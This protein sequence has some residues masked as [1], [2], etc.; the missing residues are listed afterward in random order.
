MKSDTIFR[1]KNLLKDFKNGKKIYYSGDIHIK[2]NTYTLIKGANGV[3]KTTFLNFL[4]T[5]D[6]PAFFD[7]GT[8]F[9]TP[10]ASSKVYDYSQLYHWKNRF[11]SGFYDNT[12]ALRRKYFSFLPQTGNLIDV[13]SI[14]DNLS[15][16]PEYHTHLNGSEKNAYITQHLNMIFA[17]N[18]RSFNINLSPSCLSGGLRQRLALERALIG[19][20][21]V[22]FA[23][24]PTN[25]MDLDFHNSTLNALGNYVAYKNGTVIMITHEYERA[26][27]YLNKQ[28]ESI[29]LNC[30]ELKPE[31]NQNGQERKKIKLNIKRLH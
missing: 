29:E 12:A 25:N 18:D 7:K 16:I 19:K 21:E 24:E 30:L 31:L 5:L 22:L 11:F 23:D 26:L 3:G 17:G 13:V 27:I 14:K 6:K 15:V 9:F 28:F 1:A 2:R 20:S 4:G 10:L 8:I